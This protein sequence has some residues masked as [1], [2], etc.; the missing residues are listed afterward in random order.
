MMLATTLTLDDWL[1]R[2]ERLHASS[3][4]LSL[5]RVAAVR[6]RIGM[7]PEFPLIVVGGTNGKGST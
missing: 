5:E 3:I 6:D 1:D 2:I 4:D 7:N